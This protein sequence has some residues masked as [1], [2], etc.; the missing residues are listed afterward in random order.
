MLQ[1]GGRQNVAIKCVDK[2]RVKH[3]GAA[4]DNLI[5]EIRLLKSLVHPHI[6]RM[7]N[8]TWDDKWDF[9]LFIWEWLVLML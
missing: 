7:D 5:T 6:V 9:N 8:F 2:S 4:V 3:S 1:V